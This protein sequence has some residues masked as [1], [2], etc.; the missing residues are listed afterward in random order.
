MHATVSRIEMRE[1][2]HVLQPIIE[3]PQRTLP[4]GLT[5]GKTFFLREEERYRCVKFLPAAKV[6][7]AG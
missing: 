1:L 7:K 3:Q 6:S 4:R 2:I 5:L